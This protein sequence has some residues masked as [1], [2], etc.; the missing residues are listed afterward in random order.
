[1]SCN[2]T[3]DII[4]DVVIFSILNMIGSLLL[5]GFFYLL[6]HKLYDIF[7]VNYWQASLIIFFII[8]CLAVRDRLK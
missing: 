7:D 5:A 4:G 6:M 3:S 8:S 1:M 2:N